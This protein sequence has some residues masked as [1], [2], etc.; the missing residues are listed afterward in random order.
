MDACRGLAN[1]SEVHLRACPIRYKCH[2]FKNLEKK[3]API[4]HTLQGPYDFANDEC[5]RYEKE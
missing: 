1:I 4:R 3:N 2:L 5:E